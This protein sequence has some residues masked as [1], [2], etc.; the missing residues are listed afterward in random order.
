LIPTRSSQPGGHGGAA[1]ISGNGANGPSLGIAYVGAKPIVSATSHITP[2]N[3][4]PAI[5]A[6]SRTMIDVTKT[7]P[8]TPAGI[9]KDILAL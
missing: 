7:I 9:S 4:P 6:R 8:A 3:A 5:A 1:G 2:G